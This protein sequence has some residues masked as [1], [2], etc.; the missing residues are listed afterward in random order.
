MLWQS[1]GRYTGH[2]R[3][4]HNVALSYCRT[5]VVSVDVRRVWRT[6]ENDDTAGGE[7][8]NDMVPLAVTGGAVIVAGV[9]IGLPL[10]WLFGADHRQMRRI[11]RGPQVTAQVV[12]VVEHGT[13]DGPAYGGFAPMLSFRSAEGESVTASG[14]YVFT[15]NRRRVPA[16]GTTMRVRYD[17]RDPRQICIQGWD[18]AA[19]GLSVFLVGPLMVFFGVAMVVSAFV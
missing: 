17:P 15:G 10:T 3:W 16:V 11:L 13:Q 18:G 14:H 6:P 4:V 5:Q 19:R 2:P 8:M 7:I 1:A 12:G 9:L